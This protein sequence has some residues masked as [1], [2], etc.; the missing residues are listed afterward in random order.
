V[1]SPRHCGDTQD[2]DVQLLGLGAGDPAIQQ[3]LSDLAVEYPGRVCLLVGFSE[4]LAARIYAAGDFFIIA[5]RFEPCGLT[6]F[7]AQLMGNLPIVHG[8][9][10]LVKTVDHRYGY[11]YLGGEGELL[12]ALRRAVAD[13]RE[14]GRP[15]IRAMQRQAVKNIFETFT[16]RRVLEKKYL[17]LYQLATKRNSAASPY[18]S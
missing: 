14:P 4:T 12:Q 9:G 1:P 6:D 10:G 11:S 13:Y 3:Q 15:T 7:F 18:E 8:I 17:P 16:W 5:S 2:P